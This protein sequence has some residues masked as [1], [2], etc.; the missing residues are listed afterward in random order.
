[1]NYQ[2]AQLAEFVLDVIPNVTVHNIPDDPDKRT[3]NLAFGKIK[4]Q[5]GCVAKK[6]VHQGI[7]EIKEAL[8]RGLIR[9]DDPTCYTLQWYK[10]LIE[11]QKRIDGLALDGKLL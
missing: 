6:T 9:G 5:L 3:Y 11:W 2:I 10:S 1:M 4:Q 8:D 7:V